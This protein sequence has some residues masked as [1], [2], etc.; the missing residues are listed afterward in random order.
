MKLGT[1]LRGIDALATFV[2]GGGGGGREDREGRSGDE[3][4]SGRA[5]YFEA[6]MAG[7]LI[8]ALREAF[9]RDSER[10]QVEREQIEAE[11][12][13]A[14]EALRL[15]IV[16]QATEREA[17][18]L[19]AMG[20]VAVVVWVMSVVFLIVHPALGLT[21]KIVLAV[22]W[23]LLLVALG[24]IAAAHR[25]INR[26]LGQGLVPGADGTAGRARAL[27]PWLV[28]SGLALT[29]ASLLLSLA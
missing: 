20:A 9:N 8:S 29:S 24:A 4:A 3:L 6:R 27:A 17:S 7:V 25:G 2:G 28:L 23:V 10:L 21:A 19:R 11:R 18:H 16:R 15:E 1:L 12:K 5:G 13:R 26:W 14:E 22:G